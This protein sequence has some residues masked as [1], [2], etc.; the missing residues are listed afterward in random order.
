MPA[1][2]IKPLYQKKSSTQVRE[3]EPSHGPEKQA[4]MVSQPSNAARTE[5][6]SKQVPINYNINITTIHN[7]QAGANQ[8]QH[9]QSYPMQTTM[10]KSYQTTVFG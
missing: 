3:K 4:S 7:V 6:H 8:Q 9:F 1:K 2:G 10:Q 5:E